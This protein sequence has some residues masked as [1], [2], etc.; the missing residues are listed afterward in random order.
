MTDSIKHTIS[1]FLIAMSLAVFAIAVY[2]IFGW[3]ANYNYDEADADCDAYHKVE[4]REPDVL[5]NYE[6]CLEDAKNTRQTTNRVG[7]L[8]AGAL[9]FVSL[10][11]ALWGLKELRG[12]IL[13]SSV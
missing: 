12:M 11:F 7:S 9:L 3:I 10:G 1:Y 2:A 4:S 6:K 13:T 8:V 5:A